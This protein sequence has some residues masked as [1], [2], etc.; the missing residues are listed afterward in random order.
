[1]YFDRLSMSGVQAA[2]DT[3]N[4]SFDTG[5]NQPPDNMLFVFFIEQKSDKSIFVTGSGSLQGGG[6]VFVINTVY[7]SSS[8]GD[9]PLFVGDITLRSSVTADDLDRMSSGRALVGLLGQ[10][11]IIGFNTGADERDLIYSNNLQWSRSFQ[12]RKPVVEPM[13]HQ[14]FLARTPPCTSYGSGFGNM[15][16]DNG[17][18]A[19]LN[20]PSGADSTGLSNGWTPPAGIRYVQAVADFSDALNDLNGGVGV[21]YPSCLLMRMGETDFGAGYT[22]EQMRD[23]LVELFTEF[24]ADVQT[25]TGVDMSRVPIVI[26]GLNE[27]YLNNNPAARTTVEAGMAEV[28][29][30]LPYSSYLSLS[31]WSSA[32]DGTHDD[33]ATVRR[34]AYRELLNAKLLAETNRFPSALGISASLIGNGTAS[35]TLRSTENPLTANL[36]GT[37]LITAAFDQFT[38]LESDLVGNG[39]LS[40]TLEDSSTQPSTPLTDALAPTLQLR[41]DFGVTTDG[42]D[43][44][45]QWDDL[46]ANNQTVTI[47]TAPSSTGSG[48]VFDSANN[49]YCTLSGVTSSS[50]AGTIIVQFQGTA[51]TVVSDGPGVLNTKVPEV[52]DNQVWMK[53]GAVGVNF[54]GITPPPDFSDNTKQFVATTVDG[55]D[56][57]VF[58]GTV[59][60][61]LTEIHTDTSGTILGRATTAIG[62]DE[63]DATSYFD[64]SVFDIVIKDGT[65]LSLSDINDITSEMTT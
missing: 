31:P 65:A 51:G 9:I 50:T 25:N 36:L 45:T 33:L 7:E 19:V 40:G 42:S 60:G 23:G 8:G 24:R 15:L 20:V 55:T 56:F 2:S 12:A 5:S 53:V 14:G 11:N 54:V 10:S 4:V 30:Y 34:V 39:T 1:M 48:V 22:L 35:G 52:T 26:I 47:V 17:H 46:S 6:T 28:P 32:S 61:S 58:H 64:G 62:R 41:S 44:V 3:F 37:G 63:A 13:E 43:N 57:K 29:D 59:G 38:E 18:K 21:N 16:I 27:D 49:E